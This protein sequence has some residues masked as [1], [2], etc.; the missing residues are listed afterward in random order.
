M[1]EWMSGRMSWG[2]HQALIWEKIKFIK[3]YVP[4]PRRR[5]IFGI[6]ICLTQ[7]VLELIEFTK[8]LPGPVMGAG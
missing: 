1:G 6:T 5:R 7:L 4:R 3:N 2:K 8:S